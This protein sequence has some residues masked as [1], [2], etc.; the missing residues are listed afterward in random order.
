MIARNN[1]LD[2]SNSILASQSPVK[3]RSY[4]NNNLADNSIYLTETE[5]NKPNF[6][7]FSKQ[8]SKS[9]KNKCKFLVKE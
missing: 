9:M 2:T 7:D 5:L 4:R 3:G 8:A 6:Y 1:P